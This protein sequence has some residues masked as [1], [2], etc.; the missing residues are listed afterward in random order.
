MLLRHL[1]QEQI[2]FLQ[3]FKLRSALSTR[4]L[5]S[6][7][8]ASYNDTLKHQYI[9][10]WQKAI[11][12][13]IDLLDF[14]MTQDLVDKD[15]LLRSGKRAIGCKQVFKQKRNANSSKYFK[16]RLVIK[17]YKQKHSIDYKE[18]FVLV[19]KFVTVQL[20]FALAALYNWEIDQMDVITAFLNPTLHEEVFIELPEGSSSTSGGKQYCCLNKSLYRLKQAPQAW[21]KNI[22][23]FLT[24]SLSLTC[25]KEDP[26]LYI[27][28]KANLILLLQ[29]DDILLFSSDK[30]AV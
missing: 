28:H 10:Q 7:E 29:V 6:G 27:N 24:G 9:V 19:A 21:Y 4:V 26:N 16:A 1:A 13:E 23:V 14:N 5:N 20:L 12:E 17:G 3:S 8:P 2:L 18:T 25:S 15:T 22:N 11:K 30:R